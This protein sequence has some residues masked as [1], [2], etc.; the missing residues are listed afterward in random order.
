MGYPVQLTPSSSS[1]ALVA[2]GGAIALQKIEGLLA[3]GVRVH[4][5]ARELSPEVAALASS[6]DCIELREVRDEDVE[7]K[8]MVIAA[9]DDR[10]VNASLAAAARARGILVNAVDDPEASTFFAPAVVR[11]G[12]VTMS[13]STDGGSPLLAAQ[14]RRL[15]EAAIPRSVESIADFF[16]SIRKR[17]LRGLAQ[18]SKLLRALADPK[19][20]RLVDLDDT[21]TASDRLLELAS[22]E[23]ESFPAGSVAVVGAGPGAKELLTLRALDRIQRADVILHDALVDEEVLSLALP[24]TRIIDV[25]RRC[26]SP[27]HRGTS[28]EL[29][30]ALLIREAKSGAR[31]VRLHAGDPCVFG[32]GG[33]E[34]DA[35]ALEGIAYELVPGVSAVLAAPAAAGVPL[36]RRGEARGFTVRTG[37]SATGWTGAELP[38]DEETIV[39]L[40]G[41]G[42]ARDLLAKLVADGLPS[43][44]PAAAISNATRKTERVVTGTV[45]DLADR[46][47]A[48]ALPSP[49][50]LVV[51]KVA[52][53]AKASDHAK[54]DA[55]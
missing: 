37:H 29:A 14:L 53:R 50:T 5:I 1:V 43:D 45:A 42:G 47:E 55:A 21:S 11:R 31:V 7:E 18:R 15:L 40:M 41:L 24:S 51:G 28:I 38:K 33:E 27:D 10:R 46:I 16:V 22:S 25:G 48:A 23:E 12:R 54:E 20:S 35:L 8:A 52:R 13:I 39:V 30:I 9:T 49:A 6:L 34:I 3:A 2:G 44:T 19:I 26:A 4:V 17:G 36:T 32:R